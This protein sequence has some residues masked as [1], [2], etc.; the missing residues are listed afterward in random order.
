[1]ADDAVAAITADEHR[2]RQARVRVAAAERGL[3][4][5][6]AFSRGGGTH[7]RIADALW[8]T[9][10]A[11]SQPFV[12]D[13]EGHWRAA[14]HIV[15]VV[16]A[17]GPCTAIVEA[18]ELQTPPVAD[19]VVVAPDLI[20]A[21]ADTLAGALGRRSSPRVGVFGS[22]TVAVPWWAALE[23]ATGDG[24]RGIRLEPAD[25]LAW[26]LRRLKSPAEQQLLRAAGAIGSRAMTAA[27]EAA[28][29]RATEADVAAA[30]FDTVV[31]GGGAVYDIVV[32]SGH[33]SGTL[34]PSG[35]AAGAARWTARTLKS[36]E[37]LRLDAYG[38]VGG[39]L[40]DFARTVVVGGEPTEA[41][42]DLLDAL[43]GAVGAG[44]ELLRPGTPLSEV[45]RGCEAALEASAHAERHGVPAHTMSGFWG[46]GL[47]LGWEPPWIGPDSPELVEPGMC[48][49]IERRA[50]VDGLGGAQYE[51][52]VLIGLDGPEL[53]TRT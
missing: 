14:G 6:V 38:S 45:A 17:G 43:R 28:A 35:G 12:P 39:Y 32:S 50:A 42:R 53:L 36:G 34:G 47:G 10:T 13:L 19:D 33:A 46:H 11:A 26:S 52:D 23:A 4:A 15:V 31:A 44:I 49:A 24:G 41:Q 51:E 37:L 7:D 29:P 9:G 5:V 2:E 27:L 1:M 16:P 25:D 18:D 22:D 8:L 48:L 3:D 40:F 21:A 20:A 30:L